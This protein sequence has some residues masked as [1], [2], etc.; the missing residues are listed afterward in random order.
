MVDDGCATAKVSGS[1]ADNTGRQNSRNG[2]TSGLTAVHWCH[3]KT[4]SEGF[5][6]RSFLIPSI[7]HSFVLRVQKRFSNGLNLLL[8]YIGGK[9][10]DD[11]SQVV[12]FLGAAGNHQDFYNKA[13][14]RSI[15]SQDVSRQLVISYSYELPFGRR[16]RLLR[17]VLKV[18]D[19][20]I[21]GW[22]ANGI[23]T[24]QTGIPQQISNGANNTGLGTSTQ[25]PNNNG[26]SA[27]LSGPVS[28]RVNEY[29]DTV[30]VL[31]RTPVRSRQHV[32]HFARSA[33]SL[34]KE[35]RCIHLQEFMI[36]ERTQ[37][38]SAPKR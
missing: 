31:L 33:R 20:F 25:R 29:F 37:I 1:A 3:A 9:L 8:S 14:E 23:F 27:K 38:S 4:N 26:T 10:I 35:Y 32:A 15:S 11:A 21:G 13:A 36:E 2:A 34:A 12:S 6:Y 19:A 7:Y 22:Q 18:V 30:G 17:G 28:D 24:Y 16:G 5:Y